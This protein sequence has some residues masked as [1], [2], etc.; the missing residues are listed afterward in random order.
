MV[1]VAQ[2]VEL[3]IVVQEV[4]GSSPVSHPPR[5]FGKPFDPFINEQ[6]RALLVDDIAHHIA[7]VFATKITG[8]G[9]STGGSNA[10]VYHHM[11]SETESIP[12]RAHSSI[13][14]RH[15]IYPRLPI[16]TNKGGLERLFIQWLGQDT[17]IEAF[18][19]IHEYKHDWLRRPYLKDDGMPAQYSPDFLVRTATDLYVVETKGQGFL[20][21]ENTK[22]KKRAALAWVDQINRLDPDDRAGLDWHYVLLDEQTIKSWQSKGTRASEL[23]DFAMLRE[24][25]GIAQ[26]T[27]L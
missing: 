8:I 17:K 14:V 3:L 25:D 12:V 24:I 13:E 11:L 26:S 21:Q 19:K 7:S 1:A 9:N 20:T 27:L 16:P 4:A 2:L 23:L 5:L 22:R 15:C 10:E 18:A 6:W